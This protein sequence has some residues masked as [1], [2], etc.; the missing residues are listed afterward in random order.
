M[1]KDAKKF[2]EI[3]KDFK[4]LNILKFRKIK[5]NSNCS[6]GLLNKK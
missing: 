5:V 2:P 6:L 3:S 4:V 1:T